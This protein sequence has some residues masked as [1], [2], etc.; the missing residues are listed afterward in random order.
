MAVREGRQ[1]KGR[2]NELA[3]CRST[4]ESHPGGAIAIV[5]SVCRHESPK[6]QIPVSR[7]DI[8][9]PDDLQFA[10]F[11]D[12]YVLN[13]FS[14]VPIG[15]KVHVQHPVGRFKAHL[16]ELPIGSLTSRF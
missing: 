2:V 5:R 6:R 12:L 4:L 15:L 13:L 3:R 1:A 9:G 8:A 10:A 7:H 16:Q 11:Y 14:H